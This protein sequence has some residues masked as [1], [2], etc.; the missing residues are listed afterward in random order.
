MKKRSDELNSQTALWDSL[1]TEIYKDLVAGL[2]PNTPEK[3]VRD[4][5]RFAIDA[6]KDLFKD[7]GGESVQ[8]T[9][10]IV[11]RVVEWFFA[12]QQQAPDLSGDLGDVDKLFE[13]WSSQRKHVV[14]A[15]MYLHRVIASSN[16]LGV[17][18]GAAKGE[19]YEEFLGEVNDEVVD[20]LSTYFKEKGL[21]D[22]YGEGDVWYARV[23][24]RSIWYDNLGGSVKVERIEETDSRDYIT[25][26]TGYN[27]V[28]VAGEDEEY[29]EEETTDS[30]AD[31]IT[32]RV[33]S[34]FEA[35]DWK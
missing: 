27:T 3:D 2:P 30:L 7:L 32:S 13:S 1:A 6:Q 35:A 8:A 10:Y 5:A 9:A 33:I 18:L 26:K 4:A 34:I 24:G 17:R 31:R 28:T 22:Y 29:G 23:T 19:V 15:C 20:K 12:G 11:D 25:W 14:Q 21:A 16:T